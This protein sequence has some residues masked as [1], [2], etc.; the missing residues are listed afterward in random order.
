MGIARLGF[1]QKFLSQQYVFPLLEV[2]FIPVSCGLV[3]IILSMMFQCC[4]LIPQKNRRKFEACTV[5]RQEVRI[6]DVMEAASFGAKI[7][8]DPCF[9]KVVSD[10]GYPLEPFLRLSKA[11]CFHFRVCYVSFCP[12]YHGLKK[13]LSATELKNRSN[14]LINCMTTLN[15]I[16]LQIGYL[17]LLNLSASIHPIASAF[18][19]GF[20]K[21]ALKNYV[22]PSSAGAMISATL[23]VRQSLVV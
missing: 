7:M 15:L 5:L 10:T 13:T 3:A 12:V 17:E 22:L 16:G 9:M 21:C 2:M 11:L 4:A 8:N 19:I 18:V 20:Q 14:S 23:R 1:K 6:P